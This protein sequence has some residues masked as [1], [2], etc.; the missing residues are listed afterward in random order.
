MD[1]TTKI[2]SVNELA[3]VVFVTVD[4]ARPAVPPTHTHYKCIL[5]TIFAEMCL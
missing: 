4:R 2:Q 5:Q 1:L 3:L